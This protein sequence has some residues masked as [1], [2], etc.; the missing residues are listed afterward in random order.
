[1]KE[2]VNGGYFS[3]SNAFYGDDWSTILSGGTVGQWRQEYKDRVKKEG[4]T[5]T[6][7][8]SFA[9]DAIWAYALAL[10]KLFKSYPAG[11]D[12]IRTNHT[13]QLL[14]K[15]PPAR[16]TSVV[17]A[18]RVI[19]RDGDRYLPT[20]E[21]AQRSPSG[22]VTVGR[23]LPNMYGHCGKSRGCLQMNETSIQWSGGSRPTDGRSHP[24]THEVCSVESFRAA[25]GISC[26]GAIAVINTIAIGLFLVVVITLI[27][28]CIK[29][30]ELISGHTIPEYEDFSVWERRSKRKRHFVRIVNAV[31]NALLFVPQKIYAYVGRKLEELEDSYLDN[32]ADLAYMEPAVILKGEE[33]ADS[34]DL[35]NITV[36]SETVGSGNQRQETKRESTRLTTSTS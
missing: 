18:G 10:D 28:I 36:N 6:G 34:I 15:L 27:W 25:L 7:Y 22:V 2:F 23:V 4:H 29:R 1:M 16:P 33:P 12:T 35:K 26:T 19:F 21:M 14:K 8:A 20:V 13:T 31:V 5:P 24:S 11:L 9:H 30:R 32:M 3:L 17:C